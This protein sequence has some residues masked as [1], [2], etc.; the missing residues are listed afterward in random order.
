M[1]LLIGIWEFGILFTQKAQ[2][3]RKPSREY[4]KK[5]IKNRLLLVALK[6]RNTLDQGLAPGGMDHLYSPTPL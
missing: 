1:F 2:K 4:F 3:T 6:A 5:N